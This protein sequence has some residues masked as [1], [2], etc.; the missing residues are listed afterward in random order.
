MDTGR[1]TESLLDALT[2]NGCNRTL[3]EPPYQPRQCPNT[4]N[5]QHSTSESVRGVKSLW[6]AILERLRR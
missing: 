1:E 2:A 6:R 3:P 4:L 5:R